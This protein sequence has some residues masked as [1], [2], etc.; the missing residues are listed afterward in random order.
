[1]RDGSADDK[2]QA[3]QH[4]WW[5]VR[6]AAS[7]RSIRQDEELLG[8]LRQ[9]MRARQDVPADFMQAA[10]N[11]YAWHNIDYELAQL[12]YDSN[13]HPDATRAETASIR[14]LTFKSTQLTIELEIIDSS[15]VGQLIPAHNCP[16]EIQI[17]TGATTYVTVDEYGCFQITPIPQDQFRLRCRP[18]DGSDVLTGW[19]IL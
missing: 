11:A 7:R 9:A 13:L 19:I 3:V 6:R 5:Q 17:T 2:P 14:A 16:V 18:A 1:M 4:E 8:G 15:L 10:R 12:T